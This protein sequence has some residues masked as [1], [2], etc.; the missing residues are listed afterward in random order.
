MAIPALLDTYQPL[1]KQRLPNGP[2]CQ[3]GG[4][5]GMAWH[6]ETAA[7]PRPIA[8]AETLRIFMNAPFHGWYA[9][10]WEAQFGRTIVAA[11]LQRLTS[12]GGANS[13]GANSAGASPNASGA[14][15]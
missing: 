11:V 10:T 7:R 13:G 1:R 9:C 8:S 3:P 4:D 15:P 6:A 14:N 12:N 2:G 5:I